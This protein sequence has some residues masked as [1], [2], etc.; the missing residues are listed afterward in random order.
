MAAI[1]GGFAVSSGIGVMPRAY[2]LATGIPSIGLGVGM[3]II[4]LTIII[5]MKASLRM[6]LKYMTSSRY[7]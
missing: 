7:P 1:G 5:L 4:W 6:S 2:A 3:I